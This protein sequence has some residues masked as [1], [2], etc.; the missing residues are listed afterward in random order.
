MAE[1]LAR[2]LAQLRQARA[3]GAL[4]ED[5]YNA[6]VA[7]LTGRPPA[8]VAVQGSGAAAA[9]GGVAAGAGGVAVG[10]DVHG[11]IYVGQPTDD[12]AQAIAIYRRVYA[13]G[14][15]NL[16]L[17]GI[18]V[19]AS[20]AQGNRRHLALEQVYVAL[21]TT[22]RV[23]KEEGARG[24]RNQPVDAEREE[25]RAVTA[26]E[27]VI[28]NRRL[29]L[30][31][32][33]GSGKSTFVTH[34]G[35][36]LAL[37]SHQPQAGWLDRLAGWPTADGD[38]TPLLV[39]LRDF[40]R[41]LPARQ[42]QRPSASWLWEFVGE[43]LRAQNLDFV[44]PA[45]YKLLDAGKV[46]VLLDGL[47][48]IPTAQ[49]RGQVRDAVQ[50][51]TE[52]YPACRMVVTCRTLSYQDP[53]GQLSDWPAYRLA[54]FDEPKIDSFIA[55]WYGEL[56][57]LT[58]VTG[59][60]AVRMTRRLQEAVRRKDLHELAGNPLLLTVMALVHGHR[61]RLP[62]ARAL[63][64]EETVDIL[65]L[66][67]EQIKAGGDEEAL[68]LRALLQQVDRTDVD[69]K[70]VL[71]RLA[72]EAQQ[73]GGAGE[74]SSL[75]DIGELRLL[76][77]L[78]ELHPDKSL[79]WAEAVLEVIRLRAGLLVERAPE[80]YTFPHRTFQEY[81]AGAHLAAQADFAG[82]AASLVSDDLYWR[83]VI[84]LAVG[85][86]V[87]LDGAT[88]KP[89][90]LVGELCPEMPD[91]SPLGWCKAWLA[92]EVLL[93][94]GL[95]RVQDS[96]LGR[97][98][99]RRVR[100]RLVD[101]LRTSALP[102]VQRAEAGDVLALLGDPRFRADAWFLPDEPLLGFVEIPGGPFLMGSDPTRDP[103]TYAAERPQH[104]VTL[105]TYYIARFPVTV[106]QFGAFV[107]S[108]GY[109]PRD[110]DSLRDGPTRPV[111]WISWHEALRYCEW[112]TETLRA[113]PETPEPLATLLRRGDQAGGLWRL[114][115][116]SEAEWE[117]AARGVDGRIYPWGG[118]LTANHANYHETGIGTTSAVGCFPLGASPYGV[119]EMS[120]NVWE[121]TRSA[122][123]RDYPY[124]PLGG[125]E[126][127]DAGDKVARVLRGGSFYNEARLV[128]CGV[129]FPND[130]Y[131]RYWLN[132][133]RVVLCP[134]TPLGDGDSGR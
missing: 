80:V 84:L 123:D 113:W 82:R 1:D 56:A 106:A 59:D 74:N 89:L 9:Q 16:P 96:A 3:V 52:R 102:P 11:N 24:K 17:R 33:P 92:G 30:L 68:P 88:D 20:D 64:Y 105:P 99:L 28:G 107:E 65:L 83:Q 25:S 94:A 128:R 72:F 60:E 18:D 12:P 115:L 118:E 86:L 15:Q 4:D 97:D 85:R 46:I 51:F 13:A 26:L 114:T 134:F 110:M 7:A 44:A 124:E 53:K 2:R 101:L 45:L 48:E 61:G 111:R 95:N 127:L 70:V 103:Q 38:L 126:R 5:T 54:E 69:L 6:T 39:V 21:D 121:W 125:R 93:E 75:A 71:R 10:G 43:R 22:T 87:Y 41:T 81:L 119:E 34:L 47:D 58:V 8:A 109:M 40:A 31:G 57:R 77:A 55:A 117:K 42:G 27:A 133:F 100:R 91:A 36:C 90:A 131:L 122:S 14:C 50:V 19:G 78:A 23:Q 63:L 116:P 49:Q 79:Q 29:V 132:G 67:W 98:L 130:P 76:K 62:D 120:G 112:L 32:D 73:G 66:R 129:R 108:T 35:L 37:H 104:S